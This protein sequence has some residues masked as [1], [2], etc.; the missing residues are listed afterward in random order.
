M[1]TS[2]YDTASIPIV[3][4]LFSG[5]DE[6]LLALTLEIERSHS[7]CPSASGPPTV[8]Q[9]ELMPIDVVDLTRSSEDDNDSLG[10]LLNTP[11]SESVET[12]LDFDNIEDA[13]YPS[14]PQRAS[15]PDPRKA[16][17]IQETTA[18]IPF[19]DWASRSSK[20]QCLTSAIEGKS[21]RTLATAT[22]RRTTRSVAKSLLVEEPPQS[23]TIGEEL[24]TNSATRKSDKACG[25]KQLV[26]KSIDSIA[27]SKKRRINA[28]SV[29][30]SILDPDKQSGVD[31]NLSDSK[32]DEANWEDANKDV[33]S[34]DE[35]GDV[36]AGDESDEGSEYGLSS[37]YEL[38]N[39]PLSDCAGND[40]AVNVQVEDFGSTPAPSGLLGQ[41]HCA[42][43]PTAAPLKEAEETPNEFDSNK[44]TNEQWRVRYA[45]HLQ[46]RNGRFIR[47]KYKEYDPAAFEAI[48]VSEHIR[49]DF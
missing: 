22:S 28:H 3:E 49:N 29:A 16:T 21:K 9:V 8:P 4:E 32:S 42:A 43:D 37:E 5:A 17:S 15:V 40:D 26:R 14:K 20:P 48:D 18:S 24:K 10:S 1:P 45:G 35:F 41:Q 44:L 11:L 47:A 27:V 7:I 25:S 13:V 23:E 2:H 33:G 46:A 31:T 36:S 19:S 38:D 39:E 12:I 6:D 34:D 30:I